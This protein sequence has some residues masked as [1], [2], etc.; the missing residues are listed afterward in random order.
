MPLLPQKGSFYIFLFSVFLLC[1][2]GT[3][4][5]IGY[6][7]ELTVVSGREPTGYV[8]IFTFS[9]LTAGYTVVQVTC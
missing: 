6:R 4:F 8:L 5:D 3:L 2:I 9:R 7:A 1:I